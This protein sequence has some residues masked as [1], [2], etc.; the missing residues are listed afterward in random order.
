M[1]NEWFE[2]T[3]GNKWLKNAFDLRILSLENQR[4]KYNTF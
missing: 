3:V 2:G 4:L 1:G